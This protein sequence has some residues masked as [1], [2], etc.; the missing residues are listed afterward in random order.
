MDGFNCG[1]IAC[2]KLMHLYHCNDEDKVKE[3]Y[4]SM[5]IRYLAVQD[6]ECL[7]EMCDDDIMVQMQTTNINEGG[8][9]KPSDNLKKSNLEEA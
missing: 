2:L 3:V 1:P 8:V 4:N 7:A 5:N 9:H 6:W